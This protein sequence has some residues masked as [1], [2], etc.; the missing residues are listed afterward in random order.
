MYALHNSCISSWTRS[1]PFDSRLRVIFV[2]RNCMFIHFFMATGWKRP[3]IGAKTQCALCTYTVPI[4]GLTNIVVSFGWSSSKPSSTKCA[5][6]ISPRLE[7]R[8]RF[9]RRAVEFARERSGIGLRSVIYEEI[10]EPSI[11]AFWNLRSG[12]SNQQSNLASFEHD[13]PVAIFFLGAYYDSANIC[14]AMITVCVTSYSNIA[15]KLN[16][17]LYRTRIRLSS[18]LK[19]LTVS[20]AFSKTKGPRGPLS[21]HVLI[22][23]IQFS[24][25][26]STDACTLTFACSNGYHARSLSIRFTHTSPGI[27]TSQI[28]FALW[29]LS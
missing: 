11:F 3:K 12:T 24:V 6:T 10:T 29:I 20:S 2:G 28:T 27:N 13:G 17:R 15:E 1:C 23:A 25:L 18:L 19:F 7:A 4:T 21:R 26:Q 16:C 9:L 5:W 8:S 14:E 22:Y